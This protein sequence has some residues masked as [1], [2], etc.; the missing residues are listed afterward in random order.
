MPSSAA[1]KPYNVELVAKVIPCPNSGS[2]EQPGIR[3]R[4]DAKDSICTSN[5][6][7]MA[8]IYHGNPL[9]IAD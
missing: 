3:N 8:F 5:G 2:M 7:L 4:A 6:Y 1:S 9:S